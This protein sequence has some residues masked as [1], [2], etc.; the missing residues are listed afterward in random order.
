MTDFYVIVKSDSHSYPDNTSA[1]FR[2][3]W[4]NDIQVEGDWEAALTT[5]SIFRKTTKQLS[6]VNR[7]IVYFV[8]GAEWYEFKIVKENDEYQL[9]NL[10][11]FKGIGYKASID[12]D[13]F[14]ISCPKTNFTVWFKSLDLAKKY[15]FTSV[16]I[17]SGSNNYVTA[18]NPFNSTVEDSDKFEIW[19][20]EENDDHFRKLIF[21]DDIPINSLHELRK[22]ILDRSSLIFSDII[23][24]RNHLKF[25]LQKDIN[26]VFF[27]KELSNDLSLIFKI[28]YQPDIIKTGNMK[29]FERKNLQIYVYSDLIDPIIV[30]DTKAPLLR[31]VWIEEKHVSPHVIFVPI[32]NLMYLPLSK[33]S[34]NNFEF[35]L[36]NDGGDFLELYD[37]K[38]I[39]LTIHLRRNAEE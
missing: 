22:Y 30:G 7:S 5:L 26:K 18:L 31:T 28:F 6:L 12:N 11:K 15:G 9:N 14:M 20:D 2:V 8:R 36:R 24:E 34:I 32:K 13:R 4:E 23:I 16:N 21:E 1:N 38:N 35:N 17:S 3:N 29:T 19:Y 37:T 27:D 39:V 33:N 25:I 10:G